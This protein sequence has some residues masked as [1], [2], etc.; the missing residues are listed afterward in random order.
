MYV[1][2]NCILAI[3]R[4]PGIPVNT[5]SPP[6]PMESNVR[7][8]QRV[9]TTLRPPESVARLVRVLFLPGSEL[10]FPQTTLAAAP[11]GNPL[12]SP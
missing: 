11:P 6:D 4:C 12:E 10:P 3:P 7:P 2:L 5:F 1:S 8:A 9:R